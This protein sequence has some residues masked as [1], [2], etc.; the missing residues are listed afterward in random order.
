M[1][2]Q[3]HGPIVAMFG[4]CHSN[5]KGPVGKAIIG[6]TTW[7]WRWFKPKAVSTHSSVGFRFQDGH[8]VIFEAREGKSWQGPIP[9]EKVEAWVRRDP[10]TRRFTKYYVP[11][12][13]MTM[14]TMQLK[15]DLCMFN[16]RVWIYSIAQLPRM[17]LRKYLPFLPINQTP[18]KVVC[19]EAATIIL[20]PQVPVLR[21]AKKKKADL[22]TPFLYERAMRKICQ[23]SLHRPADAS[24][25]YKN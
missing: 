21:Y 23:P 11:N 13:Y 22:V 15:Y 8:E 19:S 2:D 14:G 4:G 1:I 3:A 10:K 18:D 25:A 16:L 5:T 7:P 12:H 24:D 20:H 6:F 9:V 17:G